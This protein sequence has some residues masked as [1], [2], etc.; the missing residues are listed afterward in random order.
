MLEKFYKD[1]VYAKLKD[2]LGIANPMMV[3]RLKKIVINSCLS[4]ATQNSKVLDVAVAE[5]TS[6]T[7][8]KPILT[9]AK[10]SIAAFKLREGV[11]IGC[12]VTLRRKKM[13]EFLNRLIN[14]ALPRSRD[15]RGISPKGFDGNGNFTLGLTE[16]NIF[17]EIPVETIDKSRGMNITIVTSARTNEEAE[18]LLRL[19]GFPFR[20]K[21]VA[22]AA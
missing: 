7:G 11:P 10:K 19:L 20:K 21:A 22:E 17:P 16:Q 6:I 14:V 18:A 1:E 3:P 5:M 2:Q 12:K 9:K 13:Y 8:Q 4:E 15:F